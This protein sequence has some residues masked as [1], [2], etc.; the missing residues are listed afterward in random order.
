MA[1]TRIRDNAKYK[2]AFLDFQLLQ[3][4]GKSDFNQVL[5]LL[6]DGAHIKAVANT[7][8]KGVL[9]QQQNREIKH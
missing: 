8:G 5:Y 1:L 9:H 4:A 2:A 7:D 3:A 6:K